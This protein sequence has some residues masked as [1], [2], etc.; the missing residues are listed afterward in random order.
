MVKNPPANARSLEIRIR[1]LGLEDPL[2]E[3]MVTT[4]LF[5]PGKSHRKRSLEGYSPW[6]RK[7][8]HTMEQ[9]RTRPV[10]SSFGELIY[11]ITFWD[12]GWDSLNI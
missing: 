4:L 8:S 6:G 11:K 2:E 1:S 10:W 7:E 5:L 9:L 3:E 12:F